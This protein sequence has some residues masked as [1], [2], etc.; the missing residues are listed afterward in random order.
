VKYVDIL[1]LGFGARR[2]FVIY[3][4]IIRAV[5]RFK[6][7]GKAKYISLATHSFEP[8]AVR[9]AT[10]AGVYDVVTVAYNF[11]KTNLDEI[12]AAFKYAAS[13]GL[14]IIVMKTCSAD[15]FAFSDTEKPSY[16]DAIKWVL[17]KDFIERSSAQ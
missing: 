7:E 8:E 10:D 6:S 2:K 14:G 12:D 4:P 13:A 15:P 1:S 3:E 9:A 11:K 16:R 17:K 5:K